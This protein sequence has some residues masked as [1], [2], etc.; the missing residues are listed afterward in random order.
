MSARAGFSLK[1]SLIGA[2]GLLAAALAGQGWLSI[3]TSADLNARVNDEATS[4]LPRIDIL[5][6][7]AFDVIQLRVRQARHILK[8]DDAAKARV[9]VQMADITRKFE[10]DRKIY[11]AMPRSDAEKAA[12][13]KTV[14]VAQEFWKLHEKLVALSRER[15][16][17][18]AIKVLDGDLKPASDAM[19]DGMRK[20]LEI[21]RAG[22]NDAYAEASS[23][24]ATARTITFLVLGAGMLAGLCVALFAVF[25][26][27]R[28]INELTAAMQDI[29]GGNLETAVPHTGSGNE[30]GTMART[31]AVFRDKL[32]A[33]EAM[34]NTQK[35]TAADLRTSREQELNSLKAAAEMIASVNDITV[36]LALL[37]ASTREVTSSAQTIAAASIEMAT[38]VQQIAQNSEN[39]AG[40]A[41]ATGHTVETGRSAVGKVTA[42]MG[43][44]VKVVEETAK[45]VDELS[46]ASEQIGQILNVIEGIASQTNLLALNATIEAA[47]AGE[48]GRGF[49]VVASEVKHLA[50]Q[51][52]GA[53]ED[54][55]QRIAHLRAGMGRS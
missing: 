51:T 52:S 27:T 45:S 30:L 6:E 43:N 42:A 34:R 31:L 25:R 49:A 8:Q 21:A 17:D 14:E 46:Q 4:W 33:A 20:A 29:S 48:A 32:A 54:I 13:A 1:A 40:D 15:K 5:Q 47:R 19:R 2:V 18:E 24:Y 10:Q 39:A 9:E 41:G 22:A 53:T 36:D 23:E 37:D 35:Q 11:E 38:S 44:I 26:I 7:L 16:A 28:P 12:Y 3:Q 50:N 55:T